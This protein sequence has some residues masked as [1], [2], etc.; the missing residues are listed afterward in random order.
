MTTAFAIDIS[1]EWNTIRETVSRSVAT[2]A[3]LL[4]EMVIERQMCIDTQLKISN[5][6]FAAEEPKSSEGVWNFLCLSGTKR[7]DLMIWLPSNG[8]LIQG[9]QNNELV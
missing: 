7:E 9:L 1:G 8:C 3:V 4:L 2:V 5:M 6:L